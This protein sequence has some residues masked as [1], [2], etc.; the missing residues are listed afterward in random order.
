MLS[1]WSPKSLNFWKCT[2]DV[3]SNFPR[4]VLRKNSEALWKIAN[5][6]NTIY[7][8]AMGYRS[9]K[10]DVRPFLG[11]HFAITTNEI[12][13]T[14]IIRQIHVSSISPRPFQPSPVLFLCI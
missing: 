6:V 10:H 14:I 13:I 5:N 3:M 1:K 4:R 12:A 8:N 11:T 7:L 2:V 9:F